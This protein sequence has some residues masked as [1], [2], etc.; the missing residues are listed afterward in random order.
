MTNKLCLHGQWGALNRI[1]LIQVGAVSWTEWGFDQDVV[2]LGST[3]W[4]AKV[5][6]MMELAAVKCLVKYKITWLRCLTSVGTEHEEL[7]GGVQCGAVVG[8]SSWFTG[9][10][11]GISSTGEHS[12]RANLPED[13]FR[14]HGVETGS[15]YPQGLWGRAGGIFRSVLVLRGVLCPWGWVLACV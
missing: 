3:L 11:V 15:F 1:T 14:A 9:T 6:G 7:W 12:C 13:N 10:S 2:A 4:Q 8:R 5:F